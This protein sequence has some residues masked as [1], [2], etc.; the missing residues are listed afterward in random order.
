MAETDDSDWM[1]GVYIRVEDSKVVGRMKLHREGYDK[2]RSDG[3][4][5][6]PVIEN[7]VGAGAR[8][9]EV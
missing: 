5:R 8:R 3:W 7:G 6:R 1:E 2:V 4:R 9:L